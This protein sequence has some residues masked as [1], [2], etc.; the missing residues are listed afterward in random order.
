MASVPLRTDTTTD[1]T[2]A[3][4]RLGAVLG[5]RDE[6][7]P[8]ALG[9]GGPY[10][11]TSVVDTRRVLTDSDAFLFPVDVT[12]RATTGEHAMI[13]RLRP[14]QVTRGLATF[15]HELSRAVVAWAADDAADAMRVLREPVARSTTD[16][17]LGPLEP[18]DRDRVAD[19]VLAWIDALAPVIAAA[20]P[21]RRWSNTRRAERAAR[22][23]LERALA[24]LRGLAAASP[25]RRPGRPCGCGR[26]R[27]S[28]PA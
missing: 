18:A 24:D 11:V 12:R 2:L 6:P 8:V 5:L 28:R 13:T 7:G 26:P 27:G 1:D 10:L 21:P 23:D 22:V 25:R 4:G 17:V 19:L 3:I 15:E 16:A 20:R 9:P 14:D